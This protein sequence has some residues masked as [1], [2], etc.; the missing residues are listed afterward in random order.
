MK[1]SNPHLKAAFLEVVD[2]QLAD[3]DP[4]E[5]RETL[6]R[7]MKKGISE[8]DAKIYIAQVASLEMFDILKHQKEFNL[9]RYIKNLNRLPKEPKL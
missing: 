9:N 4:P 5:T 1:K 6:N 3:N 8:G 2:N 7:L